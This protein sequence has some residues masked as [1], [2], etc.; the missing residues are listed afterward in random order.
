MQ[1]NISEKIIKQEAYWKSFFKDS[2][3]IPVLNLPTDFP[4]QAYQ[5]FEGSEIHFEI[6]EELTE[7][8]KQFTQNT[9]TTLFHFLVTAYF[10]LLYKYS[11]QL[12]I[13]IG[14]SD[15]SRRHIDLMNMG[16]FE[17]I[18]PI[19]STIDENKSFLE[20]QN[21]VKTVLL[22]AL[23]NQDYKLE[24]LIDKLELNR[25]VSRNP[26]FDVSFILWNFNR[27]INDKENLK[28]MPYVFK[29]K[30][31]KFDIALIAY[32]DKAKIKFRLEYCPKLFKQ[33]T[34]KRM[35]EHYKRILS[36]VLSNPDIRLSS[37]DI[38]PDEEK[39][40]ILHCFNQ[41][42]EMN[43]SGRSLKLRGYRIELDEIESILS[44]HEYVKNTAVTIKKDKNDNENLVAYV[45]LNEDIYDKNN[46]EILAKVQK[47][48]ISQ[49]GSIWDSFYSNIKGTSNPYFNISGW[50][51]SYDGK[52]IPEN[53]MRE[54]F[55]STIER[56]LFY[57]PQDILEIGCG[58]GM[59]L[60]E[61]SP[62]CNSYSAIDIS[63]EA[64]RYIESII[65][66]SR[67]KYKNV[68][69]QCSKPEDYLKSCENE[70]DFI[71]MNSVVQY[72][73]DVNYLF[74]TIKGI[75]NLIKDN[76]IIY[77]GDI[78]NYD[79]IKAFHTSVILHKTS[80]VTDIEVLKKEIDF[81]C[82]KE[83]ELLISPIFF[84]RLKEFIPEI[85][86]VEIR[87][88]KGNF[89]NELTRFRYDVVLHIKQELS[90]KPDIKV[91]KWDLSLSNKNIF[92]K[93][94]EQAFDVLIIRNVPNLRM[95]KLL[96]QVELIF[97]NTDSN[98]T[99]DLYDIDNENGKEVEFMP[100]EFLD[101]HNNYFTEVIWS[102]INNDE[103]FDVVYC[104]KSLFNNDGRFA[105]PICGSEFETLPSDDKNSFSN[106]PLK[107]STSKDFIYEIKNYLKAQLPKYMIPTYIMQIGEI[108]LTT[109]K[110]VD[111]KRLPDPKFIQVK[112]ILQ[113][114]K[115]NTE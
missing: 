102:G 103:Y 112:D 113:K 111:Y 67:S 10:T 8:I 32:E 48:K 37:V 24:E 17:N 55:D 97:N 19:R 70:Y 5:S 3:D 13:V 93:L 40:T 83:E 65:S 4:R 100:N 59:F 76:G 95:K 25:D 85:S 114:S 18:L 94:D 21:E 56:I 86:N 69:L 66:N 29:N 1:N 73:P 84:Y 106:T 63:N 43:M 33:E 20:Y 99:R 101:L 27:I 72:F 31:S 109:N 9:G 42:Y 64:I 82:I 28:F 35:S 26:F 38:L 96:K 41:E 58:T 108:P 87:Y 107:Q 90:Y 44:K 45:V 74:D 110:K 54:W 98:S 57:N 39:N 52:Q 14:V 115:R 62:K 15:L 23:N 91:I 105:F 78:R 81:L 50:N 79:L 80:D 30:F 12:D 49:W 16:T 68:K 6:S 71:L 53:E 36:E 75:T 11:T 89:L 77:I 92:T 2:S 46:I 51:N 60:F 61:I 88:K 104:K 22:N 7:E 47:S 34:I